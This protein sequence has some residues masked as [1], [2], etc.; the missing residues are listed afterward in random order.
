MSPWP[1]GVKIAAPSGPEP[2]TKSDRNK[3]ANAWSPD[4]RT[5]AFH[6][7]GASTGYDL[8]TLVPGNAPAPFLVTPFRERGAAFSPDG[9]WPAYASD[10]SGR[11]EVYVQPY[12]GPGGKVIISTGG[13]RSPR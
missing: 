9:R 7:I 13:G 3:G 10:E 5:L 1:V 2:L 4:G 8:W 11:D 6:E 12:P